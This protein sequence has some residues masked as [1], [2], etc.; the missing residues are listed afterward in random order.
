MSVLLPKTTLAQSDSERE[1][2]QRAADMKHDLECTRKNAEEGHPALCVTLRPSSN[3]DSDNSST[4]PDHPDRTGSWSQSEPARSGS[5]FERKAELEMTSFLAA[6]GPH[7]SFTQE[8]IERKGEVSFSVR[9]RFSYEGNRDTIF[10][11]GSN[12]SG[13]H[14]WVFS[15]LGRS[16]AMSPAQITAAIKQNLAF[17]FPLLPTD[18]EGQPIRSLKLN[19]T[20][21]LG[22]VVGDNEVEVTEMTPFTFKFT[23]KSNHSLQGSA[24]HG[25]FRDKS[26]ELW[27]F[28]EGTGVPTERGWRKGV[29]AWIAWE[30]WPQMGERVK[31]YVIESGPNKNW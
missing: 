8:V 29:N 23:A 3:K 18:D 27:L 24:V 31:H 28:Q 16:T 14:Y 15:S 11:N 7:G 5:E 25:V 22:T 4:H 12:G 10:E 9:E 2:A 17:I 6:Y 30:L 20:I 13:H 19:E 1:A 21:H 26:G